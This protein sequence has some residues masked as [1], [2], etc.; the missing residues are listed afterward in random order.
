MGGS[1]SL[2]LRMQIDMGRV[3]G[4]KDRLQRRIGNSR[5]VVGES[6]QQMIRKFFEGYLDMAAA[7]HGLCSVSRQIY[8]YPRKIV[9]A[10]GNRPVPS[11]EGQAYCDSRTR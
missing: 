9:T 6:E 3:T 10:H 1:G 2:G 4:A 11:R 5:A 8:Q 7:G